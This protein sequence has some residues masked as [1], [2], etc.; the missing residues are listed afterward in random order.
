MHVMQKPIFLSAFVLALGGGVSM[1]M[2]ALSGTAMAQAQTPNDNPQIEQAIDS[3]LIGT[4]DFNGMS[5]MLNETEIDAIRTAQEG[6]RPRAQLEELEPK[7]EESEAPPPEIRQPEKDIFF[8]GM[9]YV[10]PRQWSAWVNEDKIT[11]DENYLSHTQGDDVLVTGIGPD[12]AE[13]SW[14]TRQNA[15]NVTTI[16]MPGQTYVTETGDVKEG[17]TE[18]ATALEDEF[19]TDDE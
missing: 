2:V 15:Q 9:I 14:R 11:P 5:F 4:S 7:E 10:G 12:G 1:G 3:W 6:V 19:I 18:A 16:L 8:G 13:L 17:R